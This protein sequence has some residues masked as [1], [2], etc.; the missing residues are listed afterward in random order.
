MSRFPAAFR[1]ATL[2][3]RAHVESSLDCP[4]IVLMFAGSSAGSE[5]VDTS[6]ER[7]PDC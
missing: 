4:P 2:D 6:V 1:L 3:S 5:N 7:Q